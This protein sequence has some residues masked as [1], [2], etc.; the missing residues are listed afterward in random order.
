MTWENAINIKL[1][2][3]DISRKIIS[4]QTGILFS[5]E[6]ISFLRNTGIHFSFCKTL[7]DL[8]LQLEKVELKII[9]TS[10][11]EIPD[12]LSGKADIK[13]FTLSDLPINADVSAL[14]WLS[15]SELLLLLNYLNTTNLLQSVNKSNIQILLNSAIL[16]NQVSVINNLKNKTDEIVQL[17]V[18]Y[19]N[20]LQLGAIYG[21]LQYNVYKQSSES[22]LEL[23]KQVQ[24]SI[25]SY[26]FDFIISGKLKD[27]F[28]EPAANIKSVSS[29]IQYLKSL[30][31]EKIALICFD[32]M[33]MA[34]WYLL[35]DFLSDL[36]I[37]FK[38]N[39]AFAL[40]PSITSISRASIFYGSNTEVYQLSS[41]NE[42]KALQE[43]FPQNS[44][45]IFREKD[46]IT[47]DSLLGIDIVS[48]IYNFF[49]DISH[50]IVFPAQYENK[51]I[52]FNA[53][54]KYLANS[55]I[56]SQISL[57]IEEGYKIFFCSDHGSVIAKGNGKKVEKYL[58]DKFVKRACLINETTLAEFIDFPQMKI[59]FVDNKILILPE[60][61]TM[62]DN[63]KSIEISH[64]GIT[65]DEIVVPFIEVVKC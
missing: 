2:L 30:K 45:E 58:Q 51:G 56:K 17:K 37:S 20:I 60:G 28:Y 9:I 43:N 29:I 52:Y 12:Y 24:L 63:N 19:D 4:D 54:K 13:K 15:L 55:S 33:G 18:S 5:E 21:E 32:C 23:I 64:G 53:V 11:K 10:L 61:R 50:S 34:E 6:F 16:H 44:C 59:P 26:S 31:S 36:N 22:F 39:L 47:S 41:V 3:S 48:I 42:L 7:A 65:V 8:L 46:N 49:D 1:N 62:F 35:R 25:D 40:I 14:E 38:T 27:I 57:L